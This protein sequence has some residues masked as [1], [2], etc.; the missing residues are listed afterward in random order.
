MKNVLFNLF[1]GVFGVTIL[2]ILLVFLATGINWC[3]SVVFDCSFA[4]IHYTGIWIFYVL[5]IIIAVMAYFIEMDTHSI[6]KSWK[7]NKNT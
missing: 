2:P 1:W 3:L 5:G 7:S 4:S 6:W